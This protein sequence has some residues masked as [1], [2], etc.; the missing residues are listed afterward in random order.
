MM[1][2]HILSLFLMAALLT[3]ILAATSCSRSY[4]DEKLPKTGLRVSGKIT[5]V[6]H[7]RTCARNHKSARGFQ[8]R[9]PKP[10]IMVCFRYFHNGRYYQG[11]SGFLELSS[12]FK[13]GKS[14]ILYINRKDPRRYHF[15]G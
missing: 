15:V 11:H 3:V 8:N 2:Q 5:R 12:K 1:D 6:R 13:P 9:K 14:V 7:L 4:R 10:A